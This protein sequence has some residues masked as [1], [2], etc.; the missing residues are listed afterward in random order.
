M[1]GKCNV[2]VGKY[3]APVPTTLLLLQCECSKDGGTAPAGGEDSDC[4]EPLRWNTLVDLATGTPVD[5]R[6]DPF[7]DFSLARTAGMGGLPVGLLVER[8]DSVEAFLF[9]SAEGQD[10][11]CPALS[12]AVGSLVLT[13]A[14]FLT[15]GWE[16]C[17]EQ[18]V[19][20]LAVAQQEP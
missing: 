20:G 13:G 1:V 2:V 6:R 19:Q 8:F 7:H 9:R 12:P 10:T 16:P 11:G 15:G 18:E 17:T 4:T 14:S 3:K 5:E